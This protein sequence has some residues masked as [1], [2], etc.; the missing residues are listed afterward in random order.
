[1]SVTSS[2]LGARPDQ[3]ARSQVHRPPGSAEEPAELTPDRIL[4]LGLGFWGSK[5]LLS[6]LELGVFTELAEG[7]KDAE[8]LGTALNLHPRGARDFFDALV[9]LGML[10][11][12]NGHYRN[13]PEGDVFMDRAKPGYVG[14]LLEMANARLYPSWG[15]LTAGLKSGQPQNEVRDANDSFGELYSDPAR[16]RQF[17]SAM[18][19]ISMSA[20]KALAQQFPWESFRTF[21]DVGGAQGCVAVQLALAHPHLSGGNFDLPVVGPIF[22]E[23]A[24]T[25]GLAQRL[26]FHAGNFFE[27]SLPHAD[28]IIMGHIL[29]DWDR[30]EKLR[31]IEKAY[32]ALP[33]GGALIVYE[34]IIDDDR[35]RNA[36]GLLMSL[37]MLLETKGGFDFTGAD[38]CRWMHDAGFKETRVEPLCGPDS[39]VVGLK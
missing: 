38:C 7:P 9:A 32:A 22:N 1:M 16:L 26:R 30:E 12:T 14:G 29:H 4:Q 18:T 36:F 24:Q 35:R 15:N 11:R 10:Q 39:M 21:I 8:A 27:D 23:Y 5:T 25:F 28:A 13:T 17:L 2:N 33:G 37:N 34:A 6:A 31:L 20:A 19:G 3:V